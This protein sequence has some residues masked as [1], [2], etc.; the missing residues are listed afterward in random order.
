[1]K[2]IYM[3]FTIIVASL[4]LSSCWLMEKTIDGEGEIVEKEYISSYASSLEI[5]SIDLKCGGKDIYTHVYVF[6]AVN[7]D[8]YKIV[9][10]GQQNIIDSITVKNKKE[11]LSITGNFYEVYNTESLI[12]KIYGYVFSN[13]SIKN[14]ICNV[15]TFI[16]AIDMK[17]ELSGLAHLKL[18]SI[19]CQKADIVL[20]DTSRI[21]GENINATTINLVS[22]G[23]STIIFNTTF[24][25]EITAK[26]SN[27]SS[28][29]SKVNAG[30]IKIELAGSSYSTLTGNVS[31]IK[32]DASGSSSFRGIDLVSENA[33]LDASG[34]SSIQANATVSL[35][36]YVTGAS[37]LV[38]KGSCKATIDSSGESSINK[39]EE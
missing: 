4:F 25:N 39:L 29:Q 24:S 22:S 19:E 1:M 27:S 2:K 38:Y 8:E 35:K 6:D 21:V 5:N 13:F 20:E 23:S 9:L 26:L 34:A 28:V 37:S 18:A 11:K 7:P 33:I 31:K 32:V 3:L 12:V 14:A 10:E 36:A 16:K 30:S 15:D 17:I